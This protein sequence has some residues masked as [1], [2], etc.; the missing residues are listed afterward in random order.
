MRCKAKWT[1]GEEVRGAGETH[2]LPGHKFKGLE[3]FTEDTEK[4][5]GHGDVVLSIFRLR[6]RVHSDKHC[7]LARIRMAQSAPE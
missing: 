3:H 4:S 5:G 2:W 1:N 6:R 7:G